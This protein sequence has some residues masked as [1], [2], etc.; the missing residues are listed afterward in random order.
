MTDATGSSTDESDGG[1]IEFDTEP[2][3]DAGFDADSGLDTD[4]DTVSVA[5]GQGAED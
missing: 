5:E 2:E 4:P 3:A 1:G